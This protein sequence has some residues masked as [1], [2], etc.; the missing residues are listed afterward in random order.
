[1]AGV[2][3]ITPQ[4][5]VIATLLGMKYQRLDGQSCGN[6]L[7]DRGARVGPEIVIP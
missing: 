7:D 2:C 1:M 3:G 6:R 4:I 5:P